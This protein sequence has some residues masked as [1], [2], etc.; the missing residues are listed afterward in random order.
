MSA[1]D[2]TRRHLQ[3]D[4]RP[5]VPGSPHAQLAA[6]LA[7]A[8]PHTRQAPVTGAIT[9]LQHALIDAAAVIAY[10]HMQSRGLVRQL[11]HDILRTR[12]AECIGQ[13]LP[14]D[15]QNLF[16]HDGLQRPRLAFHRDLEIR[17]VNRPQLI[18]DVGQR[19]CQAGALCMPDAQIHHPFSP[20]L[21][22]FVRLL[23]R[24][25]KRLTRRV[26]NRQT[27]GRSVKAE[28]Q[29]E[30]TLQQRVVQFAGDALAFRHS[31]R[32]PALQ[33]DAQCW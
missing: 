7:G 16:L 2:D 21:H 24:V 33:A 26:A 31:F 23:Q 11:R 5:T 15:Q 12:V 30:E 20:L 10:A 29:P 8:L 1:V 3:I 25:V 4:L 28:R 22:H 6:H 14:P 13:R 27:V 9:S 18:T 32:K 17:W 19:L